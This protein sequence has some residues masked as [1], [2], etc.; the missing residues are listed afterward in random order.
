MRTVWEVIMMDIWLKGEMD[1][2]EAVTRIKQKH[3]IPVVYVTAHT[4]EP[5][6]RR[7]MATNPAGFL[8]KPAMED[9]IMDA[10]VSAVK[11]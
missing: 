5:T 2:I 10:I 1:G 7:A 3:D 11:K 8:E 4:D 6:H 9:D